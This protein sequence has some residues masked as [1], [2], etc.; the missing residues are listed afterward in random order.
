M[1]GMGL[2]IS[3][4]IYLVQLRVCDGFK[5]TNQP[6]P[7]QETGQESVIPP[8]PSGNSFLLVE[9]LKIDPFSRL[10]TSK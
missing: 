9:A 7:K 6:E 10:L 5:K 3:S 1:P 4:Y 8:F 2:T